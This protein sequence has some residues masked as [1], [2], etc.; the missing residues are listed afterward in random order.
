MWIFQG[1]SFSAWYGTP[2]TNGSSSRK[3]PDGLFGWGGT[4]KTY[5]DLW[6]W[7]IFLIFF[8]IF[9]S[10]FSNFSMCIWYTNQCLIHQLLL[11]TPSLSYTSISNHDTVTFHHLW[12][13]LT[14]SLL[15]YL[16]NFTSNQL[17]NLTNFSYF[18][19]PLPSLTWIQALLIS[20]LEHYTASWLIFLPS[21]RSLLVYILH[22]LSG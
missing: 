20:C 6:P 21:E 14:L 9:L 17:P 11:P 13:S 5:Y 15:F 4:G 19:F 7:H 1:P 16:A 18:L 3:S 22:P 8:L 12:W 10:Y 2:D